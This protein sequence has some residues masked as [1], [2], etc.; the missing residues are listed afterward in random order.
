MKKPDDAAQSIQRVK[1]GMTG[2]AV[3]MLLIGLASAIFSSASSET[4]VAGGAK[5]D[6]VA[7]LAT[8]NDAA[9]TADREPLAQLGIAPSTTGNS[10]AAD[11]AK[12]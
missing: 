6:L 12:P 2:L 4:S 11:A 9:A 1:V 5:A 10:T 8:G 7:N 3:V